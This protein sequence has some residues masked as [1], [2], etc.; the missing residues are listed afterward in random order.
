MAYFKSNEPAPEETYETEEPEYD[1][2]FDELTEEEEVPELTEEERQERNRSRARLAMG[3]GN[4]VGV[5][6]GTVVILILLTLII[7]M[8]H[9]VMTDMDRNFS[10]FS[11]HFGK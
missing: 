11:I 10:L 8:V 7:S 5:I 6:A 9:F 2:G 4:L 1:D 3:A